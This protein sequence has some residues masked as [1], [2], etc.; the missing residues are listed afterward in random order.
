M[1]FRPSSENADHAAENRTGVV[2]GDSIHSF[3]PGTQLVDLLSSADGLASAGQRLTES[4]VEVH[5]IADVQV[6]SPIPQPPTIR[7]FSVFEEHL[8][9]GLAA[10][11]QQIGADFYE[12]PVFWF[13][14]ANSVVGDGALV[15]VPGNTAQMDFELGVAVVVG[16]GG[17]DL[18]PIEAL[19]HIAGYMLMNDWSA[20]DLQ[21]REMKT[22]PIGPSKGKDFATSMGPCLVTPDELGDRR[23]G[24]RL[25]LPLRAYVN[26]VQYS[27]G[28]LA[29]MYWNFGQMLS[30]ASRAVTLKPGDVLCSG[31]C[32]TG[33][34][35][36]LSTVHGVDQYPWLAEGD[37]VTL[38]A[39]VLGR[40]TNRVTWG[41][42]PIPLR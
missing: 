25:D 12:L 34:I 5:L 30:Y 26:G 3:G 9:T 7:D 19:D 31:T 14:N 38:E 32:D 28:N 1:T 40:L 17:R 33:C 22:A 11:G 23:Q 4:P 15:E 41:K 6:L 20:R 8:R 13:C 35:L 18:D 2:V 24:A 10:I 27:T 39:D 36:E 16:E 42:D 21:R 37:E 29:D